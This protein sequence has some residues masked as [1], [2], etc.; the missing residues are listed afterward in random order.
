[1]VPMGML[2]KKADF[3]DQYFNPVITKMRD[4]GLMDNI[5]NKWRSPKDMKEHAEYTEEALSTKHLILPLLFLSGGVL[6][7]VLLIALEVG[8]ENK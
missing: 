2:F 6:L 7:S 8:F 4:F 5:F 3:R 1:M